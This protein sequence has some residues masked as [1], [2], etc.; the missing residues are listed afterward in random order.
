MIMRYIYTVIPRFSERHLS[1]FTAIR[2]FHSGNQFN[3]CVFVALIRIPRYPIP[4]RCFGN[5]LLIYFI[6]LNKIDWIS[7]NWSVFPNRCF[8]NELLIYFIIL[9][10][11]DW[12]SLNWSVFFVYRV[13]DECMFSEDQLF[14]APDSKTQF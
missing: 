2:T 4:N 5:E 14:M 9:N 12:I 6:I 11:I 13:T 8:G 7:L 10:K 1:G 3:Q